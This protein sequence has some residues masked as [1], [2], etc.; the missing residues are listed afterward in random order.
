MPSLRTGWKPSRFDGRDYVYRPKA[1]SLPQQALIDLAGHTVR[2]QGWGSEGVPCCVSCS[3]TLALEVVLRRGDPD[4]HLS[5]LYHYY[6]A[7]AGSSVLSSLDFRTALNVASRG[8][9][10]YAAHPWPAPRGSQMTRADAF[11]RPTLAA[12]TAASRY[13][14]AFNP[15]LGRMAYSHVPDH[16]RVLRWRAALAANF[17]VVVGFWMTEA[18]RAITPAAPQHLPRPAVASREGH[19]VVA[20]GY[21]DHAE[22]FLMRDSRGA[23]WGAN[24]SWWLSYDDVDTD[25]VEESWVVEV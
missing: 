6:R 12:N 10:T 16:D 7:R 22:A 18:Y 5:E 14:I 24:G 13:K 8:I 9:S 11:E 21:D 4:V 15:V 19:A 1:A 3:V 17:P 2:D 23:G 25:L 20:Y